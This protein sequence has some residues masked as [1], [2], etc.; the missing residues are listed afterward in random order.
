[1][2]TRT[3]RELITRCGQVTRSGP[4]DGA[5]GLLSC[6]WGEGAGGGHGNGRDRH[7]TRVFSQQL[8]DLSGVIWVLSVL[9][10]GLDSPQ[11]FATNDRQMVRGRG[12][13]IT[14]LHTVL[15]FALL[16]EKYSGPVA[17]KN[18]SGKY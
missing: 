11:L 12:E 3:S 13:L 14:P 15:A 1:M 5:Q 7:V 6:V 16:S 2:Q 4:G 8:K 10:P 18:N 9:V 17:K